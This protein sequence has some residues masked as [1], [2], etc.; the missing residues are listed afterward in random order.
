MIS[1]GIGV[2]WQTILADLSL[3][4]FMVTASALANAP[5]APLGPDVDDSAPHHG[6]GKPP[7][8]SVSPPQSPAARPAPLT[9]SPEAEPVG[10][11]RAGAGAPPL[12][13]WLH[14]VAADPRLRLT[15]TVHYAT[16]GQ[17]AAMAQ[18]ARLSAEAGNRAAGAR[19]VIEAGEPAGASAV[20]GYDAQTGNGQ[21]ANNQT[22]NGTQLARSG[23]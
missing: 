13:Q 2:S 15:I 4:L 20:V 23:A 21:A 11:W 19:I 7:A 5:D 17:A 1:R 6:A 12:P 14:D 3:I 16:G 10:V 9:P 18:A 8:P 22:G